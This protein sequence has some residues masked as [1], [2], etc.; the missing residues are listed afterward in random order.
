[1]AL[2]QFELSGVLS[3]VAKSPI[4]A[5]DFANWPTPRGNFNLGVLWFNNTI[6]YS[7]GLSSRFVDAYRLVPRWPANG[8]HLL[9]DA[10]WSNASAETFARTAIPPAQLAK[11]RRVNISSLAPSW[12]T[13][14]HGGSPNPNPN[15]SPSPNPNPNPSP[16]PNPHP[17]PNPN[18][19]PS[20]NPTPDPHVG[21][22]FFFTRTTASAPARAQRCSVE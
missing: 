7:Q 8:A 4:A 6:A 2:R 3:R 15:P 20:P 16:S 1:M 12:N 14:C 5:V 17:N 10:M 21:Y 11:L 22:T 18:P 13:D 9:F 19:N